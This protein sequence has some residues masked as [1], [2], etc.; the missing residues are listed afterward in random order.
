[1]RH[2]LFQ[3]SSIVAHGGGSGTSGQDTSS[4]GCRHIEIYDSTFDRVDTGSLSAVNK[5]VWMRGSSGVFANNVVDLNDTSEYPDK[6][7]LIFSVG[8]PGDPGHP[9]DFQF[10]QSTITPDA[11]PDQPYLVV[12]NT[13][14][15]VGAGFI[16]ISGE[17]GEG[18]TCA[19]P[20]DYIQ[21]GRDY[22]TTNT[23]GW[24]GYT[25][26]HPLR[27]SGGSGP[28]PP[29]RLRVIGLR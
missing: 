7:E 11:T 15:G 3:D 21:S 20:G 28:P 16:T 8:C 12:D 5:W 27:S 25:Y 17:N 26:P 1:M 22:V 9:L 19:S 29:T 13:G 24:T 18:I 2:E 14:T 6:S 23:W 10:G 4:Y